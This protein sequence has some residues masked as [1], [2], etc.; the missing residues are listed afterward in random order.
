MSSISHELEEK[1]NKCKQNTTNDAMPNEMFIFHNKVPKSGSTTFLDIV[2]PLAKRNDFDLVHML[3][4]FDEN[5]PSMRQ[6]Q[7]YNGTCKHGIQRNQE[8]AHW[9]S[10]YR[11]RQRKMFLIKH[12]VYVN[13]TSVFFIKL[14]N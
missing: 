12:H 3:P 1:E 11:N 10:Q 2:A 14:D 4:C 9:V 13:F 5:D 7:T 8:L 6:D